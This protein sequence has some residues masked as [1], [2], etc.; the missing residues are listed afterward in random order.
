MA[1]TSIQKNSTSNVSYTKYACV[2]AISGY[3]LKYLIPITSREKD[4]KYKNEIKRIN[5][6]S[7]QVKLTAIDNMKKVQNKPVAESTFLNLFTQNNLKISSIKKL[8]SHLSK[9]VLGLITKINEE[10]RASKLSQIKA[11]DCHTQKIRPAIHFVSIGLFA[12]LG[13]AL[14]HN[15]KNNI[16]LMEANNSEDKKLLEQN[17]PT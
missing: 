5:Q 8:G 2:G 14:I 12:G 17:V 9:D 13:V 3:S 16:K 1:V 11:L 6:N 4:A 7:I 15:I 10:A